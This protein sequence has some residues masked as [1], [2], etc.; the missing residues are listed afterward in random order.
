MRKKWRNRLVFAYLPVFILVIVVLLWIFFVTMSELSKQQALK[1]NEIYAE[2]TMQYVDSKLR[3]VEQYIVQTFLDDQSVIDFYNVSPL[4]QN[5]YLNDRDVYKKLILLRDSFSEIDSVYLYRTRDQIVLSDSSMVGLEQFANSSYL[6]TLLA[7]PSANRWSIG[8][9]YLDN[10]GVTT[11]V[12]SL[13]MRMPL[14]LG[15]DGVLVANIKLHTLS[16]LIDNVS[17]SKFSYLHLLDARGEYLIGDDTISGAASTNREDVTVIKSEYTGWTIRSGFVDGVVFRFLS[18]LNA[19]WMVI[20]ILTVLAGAVWIVYV[21]R[22]NYKPIESLLERLSSVPLQKPHIL[23]QVKHDEFK[24]IDNLLDHLLEQFGKYRLEND[25]NFSYRRRYLFEELLTG[26]LLKL[27]DGWDKELSRFG[28]QETSDTYRVA[29]LEIDKYLNFTSTYTNKDQ[30]LIKFIIDNVVQELSQNAGILICPEWIEKHRLCVVCQMPNEQVSSDL[31]HEIMRK[32]VDWVRTNA[33]ITI[34]CGLGTKVSGL[35]RVSSSYE[36]ALEALSYKT[37]FGISSVI[38]FKDI[39]TKSGEEIFRSLPSI[40]ELVQLFRI[41]DAQWEQHYKTL[42]GEI[43]IQLFSREQVVNLMN[44][45]LF[46]FYKEMSGL[47]PEYLE[48]WRE[49]ALNPINEWI[50]SFDTV[51]ELEHELHAILQDACHRLDNLRAQ[52]SQHDLI[53]QVKAYIED[54]FNNPDFSLVMLSDRFKLTPN[55]LSRLFKE[56]FGEKF[57][58]YLAGLRIEQAKHL[59][60]TTSTAIQEIAVKVGYTHTFSFIRVFKK[61]VGRT[62]GDYRKEF[63]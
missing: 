55:Y 30:Y 13:I 5:R 49:Y 40:R 1:A 35:Q 27:E 15:T 23:G 52:R 45:L 20:G 50:A 21:S 3:T 63:H 29:I 60:V 38:D 16:K 42:F 25:E 19:F 57:I 26:T 17:R 36:E 18:N 33:A 54:E 41:G 62:P 28:F 32:T 34:T 8:R 47:S 31:L 56:E 9:E 44:Y 61:L 48:C 12:V 4:A 53:D 51:D 22:Q 6:H 58:D 14:P 37:T 10:S 46:H 2:N 39:T 24:I 7:A 59:L 43:R 11:P